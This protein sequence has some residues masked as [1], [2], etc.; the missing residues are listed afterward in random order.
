MLMDV[1]DQNVSCGRASSLK[2]EPSA[3]DPFKAQLNETL[4]WPQL[5]KAVVIHPNAVIANERKTIE[6]NLDN[7]GIPSLFV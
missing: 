3:Q 2:H 7:R 1:H 6:I 4:L 5:H